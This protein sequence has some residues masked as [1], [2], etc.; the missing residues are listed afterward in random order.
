MYITVDGCCGGGVPAV[1]AG[2]LGCLSLSVSLSRR[3]VEQ[4]GTPRAYGTME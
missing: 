3:C 4:F 1:W 2:T